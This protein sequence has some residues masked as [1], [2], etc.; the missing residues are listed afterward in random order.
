M[1]VLLAAVA[2]L[3]VTAVTIV[4][5]RENERQLTGIETRYVP[6]IELDGELKRSYANIAR[7]LEDAAGA[8][9]TSAL[10]D[11]DRMSIALRHQIEQGAQVIVDNGGDP[12]S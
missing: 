11:A 12:K 3:I 1:L 7:T 5:G 2:L 10:D 4:L 8:A 6:L 9:E